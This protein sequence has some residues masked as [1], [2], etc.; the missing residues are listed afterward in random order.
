MRLHCIKLRQGFFVAV[1]KVRINLA[2]FDLNA[3]ERVISQ[4]PNIQHWTVG[5][6]SLGGVAASSYISQHLDELDGAVFWAS[7]PSDDSLKNTPLKAL[8]V[9]GTNDMTGST[10][11]TD[12]ALL[13][14]F[15]AATQIIS[16]EG[17]NHAQFGSYGPQ[18]GD[19]VADISAE[20]Q[21]AQAVAA[22]VQFL[23]SLSK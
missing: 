23:N 16:I 14:K 13:S 6:H 8:L 15:P 3:P 18:A 2:F 17:G 12:K 22:T 21:W 1:V 10:P 7:Y 4:Y 5:G 9:Y 11:Y 19:R 20:E